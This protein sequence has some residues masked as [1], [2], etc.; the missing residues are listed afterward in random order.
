[1]S[2]S[3]SGRY[4]IGEWSPSWS[5]IVRFFCC[6]ERG[7]KLHP[8]KGLIGLERKGRVSMLTSCFLQAAKISCALVA[9]V[10]LRY[11][12]CRWACWCRVN[13]AR[14]F[15]WTS[16]GL[17]E[18]LLRGKMEIALS[19]ESDRYIF[20]FSNDLFGSSENWKVFPASCSRLSRWKN[21]PLSNQ[22]T[23]LVK[24]PSQMLLSY[25]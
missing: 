23:C 15:A 12:V 8:R 16:T 22:T 17:M 13:S 20:F 3:G 11:L 19:V 25:R 7:L 21:C 6:D 18:T 5:R 4:F 2:L 10:L 24:L 14:E 1:M 9:K